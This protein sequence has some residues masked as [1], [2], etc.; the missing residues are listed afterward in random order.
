MGSRRTAFT[1]PLPSI[2]SPLTLKSLPS[3]AAPTGTAID[4]PVARTFIPRRSPSLVS[5]ATARTQLLPRCCCTSATISVPSS[6][7][8]R[9]AS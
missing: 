9:K 4:S 3:V 1:G 5:I 8:M 2:G 6:R 7:E